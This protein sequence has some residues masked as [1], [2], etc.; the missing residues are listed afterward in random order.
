MRKS[1][2][3]LVYRKKN[4][5]PEFFLVHPGGPFWK[6]KDIGAWSVPKGEFED[7][8]QPLK[9]A[10]REFEEETGVLMEGNFIELKPVIQKSGKVVYAWG[11]E[12][13]VDAFVIRSNTFQFEW[14]PKTGKYIEIPEVDKGGWFSFEEAKEKLISGQVAILEELGEIVNSQ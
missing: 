3:L 6:N 7:D 13:D 14:P 9:A 1:A 11:V 5:L 8:E 2:G 4:S 10:I 12:G